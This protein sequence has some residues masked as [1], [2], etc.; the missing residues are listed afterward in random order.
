MLL[1]S[2]KLHTLE[3]FSLAASYHVTACLL[4]TEDRNPAVRRHFRGPKT[5]SDQQRPAASGGLQDRGKSS[6]NKFVKTENPLF[7]KRNQVRTDVSRVSSEL[8]KLCLEDFPADSGRLVIQKPALDSK[9][10]E[11]IFGVAPCFLAL[12]QRRRHAYRLFVKDGETSQRASVLKVCEEANQRGVQI[13]RVSKKDLDRMSSGGV[14]QGV[15]LCVS[16]LS[17]IALDSEAKQR[18]T[19]APLW[20]V[21]ERIQDP[22]NLG[23]IL[24]SAYFLGVDKVISS[25]RHS[26]PLSPVV[27]KASSGVMEVMGVYAHENLEEMLRLKVVQGWQVVGTVGAGTEVSH[28][29]VVP[30]SDFQMSAPTVLLMGGESEGLSPKLLSLCQTLL[31]IPAG[32][33]L[34]PGIES[35]NVSV[36][37]GILL[38]SLLF[39]GSSKTQH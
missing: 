6:Q 30:C 8:R 35:L 37:T 11:V 17:Y 4:R 22:M 3:S 2:R 21:L 15:C 25:L 5:S 38:H 20:L 1:W 32:R 27:S 33:D 16:P 36:A 39:T 9:A 28:I 23:A 24:R 14:H 31:T 7:Q 13:N 18:D 26:C 19:S 34:S 29:P 10:Q 12:T